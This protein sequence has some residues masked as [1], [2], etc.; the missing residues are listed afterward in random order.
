MKTMTINGIEFEVIHP[1]KYDPRA[2]IEAVKDCAHRELSYYYD[3]P[4]VWK[5]DVFEEWR[6]WYATAEN[7]FYFGICSANCQTFSISAL[8]T[9]GV[10]VIGIIRITRD[11]NRVYLFD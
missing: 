5:Q 8:L 11:H 7:V 2:A 4:S 3:K 10:G 9:N 1:K 6:E